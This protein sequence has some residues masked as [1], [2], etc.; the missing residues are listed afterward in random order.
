[1]AI[2]P[3]VSTSRR[4]AT[5]PPAIVPGLAVFAPCGRTPKGPVEDPANSRVSSWDEFVAKF[6]D[7]DALYTLPHQVYCFF[8]EGG[9]QAI[10][11]RVVSSD[12]VAASASF[13]AGGLESL[14][15]TPTGARG[16]V[17]VSDHSASGLRAFSITVD[18]TTAPV[19]IRYWAIGAANTVAQ[20][21]KTMSGS[22][23]TIAYTAGS[24]GYNTGATASQKRL[25]PG[26]VKVERNGGAT[27]Y[28]DKGDGTFI[29]AGDLAS[30]TVN[31][32]TGAISLVFTTGT[33]GHT[34]KLKYRRIVDRVE[35]LIIV[36][37]DDQFAGDFD[38]GG[39]NT[40]N[41]TTGVL[42]FT[43][44]ASTFIPDGTAQTGYTLV[45]DGYN[46]NGTSETGEGI[47][48]VETDGA[49]A[50][51]TFTALHKGAWANDVRVSV[52]GDPD[53]FTESTQSYTRYVVQIE[54]QNSDGD[55]TVINGPFRKIS[56]SDA[57]DPNYI[58]TILNDPT[59][60]GRVVS[61]AAV[62]PGRPQLLDG[63]LV[64]DETL[65]TGAGSPITVSTTLKAATVGRGT[66]T[67][68]YNDGTRDHTITDDGL[69][70]L[71]GSDPSGNDSLLATAA[72]TIDYDTGAISF[73]TGQNVA[74]ST[75]LA[76]SYYTQPLAQS[77]NI[78]LASGSEGSAMTR[79]M[80]SASALQATKQGMYALSKITDNMMFSLPDFAG[81][82][83]V[84][85]DMLTYAGGKT[86]LFAILAPPEGYTPSQTRGYRA[87][88]LAANEKTGALFYPWIV[89]KDPL[90]NSQ[91]T[92]S[93]E[94]HVAGIMSRMDTIFGVGRA[95]AGVDADI[96]FALGL[97]RKL[98]L[99][100]DVSTL[101]DLGVCC[102]MDSP[103][104]GRSIWGARTLQRAR[105]D[106]GAYINQVRVQNTAASLAQSVLWRKTFASQSP[107]L[108]AS[109]KR[110]IDGQIKER[111]FDGGNLKGAT[112]AEAWLVVCDGTI[113]DV[114][115][116]TIYADVYL[117]VSRPA[118]FIKVRI[119]NKL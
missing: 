44:S 110:S 17:G 30:G 92:I 75:P 102:L 26:S 51:F 49:G 25:E 57:A 74:S 96:R 12:A 85:N 11:N 95:P 24:D 55:W 83:D 16:L 71:V 20:G 88:V 1:M 113:N 82:E 66:L 39:T 43:T 9:R 31:Y 84:G 80:I 34:I 6:G 7:L 61:V 105:N 29:A 32:D 104:T 78:E 93:P 94:G 70:G 10:I 114:D 116:D 115:S 65:G 56:L 2:A 73:T 117:A 89:I 86:N 36:T 21:S 100:I 106:F 19:L 79:A 81:D 103:E 76:A 97:E 27:V 112:P 108:W 62:T 5:P 101:N 68:T 48:K 35:K 54:E 13:S 107:G 98:D 46:W 28:Y 63:A 99:D 52:Q 90:T 33:S 38:S 50:Y 111:L 23:E 77:V 60:L 15:P 14:T 18:P 118:E 40:F 45:S 72:A 67:I 58:L 53:Y 109:C 8:A 47:T 69:G 64:S 41:R 22:G 4:T 91:N 87:N 42:S 119:S 3:G 37:E 59:L